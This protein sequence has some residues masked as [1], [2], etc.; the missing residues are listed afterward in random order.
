MNPH[1]A[2]IIETS[3]TITVCIDQ[4]SLKEEKRSESWQEAEL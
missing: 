2:E 1:A 3:Q 4:L